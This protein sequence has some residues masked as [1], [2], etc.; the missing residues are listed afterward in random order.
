MIERDDG[1]GSEADLP[2]STFIMSA[3]VRLR[4]FLSALALSKWNFTF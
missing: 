2:I 3:K 1:L 4:L